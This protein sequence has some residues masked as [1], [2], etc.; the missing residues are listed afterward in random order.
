MEF[1]GIDG[2]EQYS[3]NI[4]S[5]VVLNMTNQSTQNCD[6]NDKC[7][8]MDVYID[9]M[10][11]E[12]IY[13]DT[14]KWFL[15]IAYIISFVVGL[16][17]NTLVC[18]VIWRNRGM[19]TVTNIFIVN[20]AIADIAVLIMCLPMTL[21]V[22]VT[23]T[24]FFGDVV[25]KVNQF[26]MTS[27]IS[28]SVLTLTAISLERWYAICHPLR[29]HSSVR[30]ARIIIIV[31]WIASA[32]IAM[33]ETI[34][35]RT[36]KEWP[37]EILFTRCYPIDLGNQGLMIWQFVLIAAL[38]CVP[39]SLM[40]FT[41]SNIAFILCTR[42][43]PR[44]SHT[45]APMLNDR[46]G[47]GNDVQIESRKKA[48]KMLFAIVVLFAVCFFPNHL[49]NVLR[50]AGV[51]EH[52][53]GIENFALVAHLAIFLNSCLNPIIYNFM[54]DKFRKEFR[55]QIQHCF[56]CYT[57]DQ[58]FRSTF[59]NDYRVTFSVGNNMNINMTHSTT[60]VSEVVP[61]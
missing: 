15:I 38:Y 5:D 58:R 24:W 57:P 50:Y 13:P 36:E 22:D 39:I 45:R 17:G 23:C 28:V 11:T 47:N 54:S 40:G 51:T 16:I 48:A 44:E 19:R 1:D 41:Y 56:R 25:C 35:A 2:F 20:L 46:T 18:V 8:P 33:P 26:T 29:F 9:Y 10:F 53:K 4:T 31:I 6:L 61:S 52:A 37:Q 7:M 27:S 49:L 60:A 43:I 3:S 42:R 32:C 14:G 59:P 12:G 30:R 55:T 21:L 34:A